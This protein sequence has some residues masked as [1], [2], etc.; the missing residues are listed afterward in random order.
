VQRSQSVASTCLLVGSV[1]VGGMGLFWGVILALALVAGIA[2]GA[3]AAAFIAVGGVEIPEEMLYTGGAFYITALTM[4]TL[5][6]VANL[7]GGSV[8]L[9]SAIRGYAGRPWGMRGAAYVHIAMALVFGAPGALTMNP[10]ALVW[11]V[12]LVMAIA[13]LV[14]VPQP[15]DVA[16]S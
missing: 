6:T 10:L 14:T 4:M 1:C 7:F 13:T 11:L 15:S 5:V 16:A 9:L 2:G 12:V 3:G 8:G